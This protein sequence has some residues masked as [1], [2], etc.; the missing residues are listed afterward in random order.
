MLLR[1]A[2]SILTLLFA[3]AG[4]QAFAQRAG[5]WEARTAIDG[6]PVGTPVRECRV[7]DAQIAA[8]RTWP[9]KCV[10]EPL[11]RTAS[12][13]VAQAECSGSNSGLSVKVRYELTGDLDRQFRVV[14]TTRIDG[15]QEMPAT[16]VTLRYLGS[17]A[18]GSQVPLASK[19]SAQPTPQRA[20]WLVTMLYM[21]AQ[22]GL[23]LVPAALVGLVIRARWKS[24][25]NP[26]TVVNI[27]TDAAGAADVPVRATFTGVTGL[28][29]WYAVAM[30]NATPLL[31]IEPD[32]IRFRVIR[33]QRR[34]FEEIACVDVRQA[35]G[36]VNLDFTFHGSIFTFAANVGTVQL[37][38][39]VI[40]SLPSG[41]PLSPRALA[42]SRTP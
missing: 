38:A 41:V 29:W 40:A 32:G 10:A 6:T 25:R 17:C 34:S 12:G 5:L 18:S 22:V 23:M 39:H 36:T 31:V 3:N 24:Q 26:A 21:V 4:Q 42:A 37:A 33:Q 2:C 16:A 9:A 13:I 14:N 1:T 11:R 20:S 28:P 30:N 7:A 8:L 19:A 35:P 27:V 15:V